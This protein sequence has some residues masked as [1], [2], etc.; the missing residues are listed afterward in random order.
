MSWSDRAVAWAVAIGVIAFSSGLMA[1]VL[2]SQMGV[3]P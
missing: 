3:Q 1:A 2:W